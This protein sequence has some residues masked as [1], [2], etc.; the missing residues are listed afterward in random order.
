MN[1]LVIDNF[2]MEPERLFLYLFQ[3][4]IQILISEK[5]VDF[6]FIY[7][8]MRMWTQIEISKHLLHIYHECI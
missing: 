1:K 8:H 2:T 6:D 7:I 3:M 5:I 4:F